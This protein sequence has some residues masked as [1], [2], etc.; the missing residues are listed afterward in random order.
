MQWPWKK[1]K[2]YPN[3]IYLTRCYIS[4]GMYKVLRELV[5][6]RTDT[7]MFLVECNIYGEEEKKKALEEEKP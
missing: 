1:N 2:K 7:R 3:E 6:S 5:Q 4:W